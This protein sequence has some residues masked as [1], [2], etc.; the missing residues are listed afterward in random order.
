MNK[1]KSILDEV[2][3]GNEIIFQV[4]KLNIPT[5]KSVMDLIIFDDSLL[6]QVNTV[7][8][9]PLDNNGY[10]QRN[11][12][13][14][15]KLDDPLSF[16]TGI[17]KPLIKA[18][19]Y[20]SNVTHHTGNSN[21][22]LDS[23]NVMIHD[24]KSII[25]EYA[26]MYRDLIIENMIKGDL[27]GFS[28]GLLDN[29]DATISTTSNTVLSIADLLS[30]IRSVKAK[31]GNMIVINESVLTNL[32]SV[33]NTLNR[34]CANSFL[35]TGM[36]E[37]VKVYTTDN[38]PTDISSTSTVSIGGN[39]SNYILSNNTMDINF[40]HSQGGSL[41]QDFQFTYYLGGNYQFPDK[42]VNLVVAE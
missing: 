16:N 25:R 9:M 8:S 19:P 5:I 7:S 18:Y 13:I 21:Y 42:F 6:S 34:Y 26:T 17:V 23:N 14:K 1:E 29:A 10:P 3:S 22:V 35:T 24:D 32:L 33:D 30:F 41:N 28:N 20:V 4:G 15:L 40:I 36:I 37:K 27:G 11:K 31:K 12:E 39:F 38:M 2:Y